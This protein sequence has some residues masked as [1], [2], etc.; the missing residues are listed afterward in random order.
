MAKSKKRVKQKKVARTM[1][2]RIAAMPDKEKM[3]SLG[4]KTMLFLIFSMASVFAYNWLSSIYTKTSLAAS[5][6]FALM[7]VLVV[8]TLLYFIFWV[9]FSVK[10]SIKK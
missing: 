8:I 7:I 10:S 5:I 1:H 3:R 6:S 4:I 2:A 9:I